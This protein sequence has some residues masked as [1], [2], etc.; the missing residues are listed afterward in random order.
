M[1]LEIWDGDDWRPISGWRT[2]N[3]LLARR[4][5][6][7]YRRYRVLAKGGAAHTVASDQPPLEFTVD[8]D[9]RTG[10]FRRTLRWAPEA[11]IPDF[12][13]YGL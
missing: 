7:P 4:Q 2:Q 5:L 9:P 8:L 11:G 12:A 13:W 6:L 10:T 1:R 3:R